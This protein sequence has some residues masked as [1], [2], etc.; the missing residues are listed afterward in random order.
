MRKLFTSLLFLVSLTAFS[1]DGYRLWLRYD[2]VKD[3]H[4]LRQYR[5]LIYG[6]LVD[7]NSPTD[8]VMRSELNVAM[9]GLL[10]YPVYESK[11]IK[12]KLVV[13]TT[14]DKHQLPVPPSLIDK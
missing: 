5:Q 13:F 1:E 8:S 10:G 4:L 14:F 12:D 9:N 3:H 7:G 6:W 11:G 2:E